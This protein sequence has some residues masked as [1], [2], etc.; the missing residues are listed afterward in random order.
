MLAFTLEQIQ[1]DMAQ[2]TKRL[3]PSVFANPACI[4]IKGDIQN[5]VQLVLNAPMLPHRAAESGSLVFPGVH[6]DS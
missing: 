3:R 2:H 6:G 4:F 1:R 5:P